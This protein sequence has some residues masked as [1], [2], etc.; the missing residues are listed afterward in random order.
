MKD[1]TECKAKHTWALL[2][3][4]IEK[5]KK[6]IYKCVTCNAVYVRKPNDVFNEDM[7]C[8]FYLSERIYNNEP[9]INL[10]KFSGV[11]IYSN[12]IVY[13]K[14]GDPHREDGP[15]VIETSGWTGIQNI[16]FSSIDFSE[17]WLNGKHIE[18]VES[19]EEM[20]IKNLLE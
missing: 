14:N 11:I 9:N 16:G 18:G 2:N 1:H 19:A 13:L 4:S 3:R 5:S 12:S 7:E 20:F 8:S 10:K 17:Y 6:L 15:A